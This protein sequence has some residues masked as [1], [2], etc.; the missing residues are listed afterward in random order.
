ML[1]PIRQPE[2]IKKEIVQEDTSDDLTAKLN[3]EDVFAL[4]Q[5]HIAKANYLL[6][7]YKTLTE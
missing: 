4:A 3:K 1:K 2:E 5:Y 7:Y 6:E